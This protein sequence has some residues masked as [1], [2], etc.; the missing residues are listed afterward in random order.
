MPAGPSITLLLHSQ[1]REDAERDERHPDDFVNVDAVVPWE[2]ED[3]PV[4]AVRVEPDDDRPA[5]DRGDCRSSAPHVL[6][7]VHPQPVI[8]DRWPAELVR[9]NVTC[10][11]PVEAP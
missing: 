9:S 11:E 4:P 5:E 7:V 3:D 8:A 6:S 10:R 1:K 2:L